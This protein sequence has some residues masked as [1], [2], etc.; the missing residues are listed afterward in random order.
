MICR[1]HCVFGLSI[2]QYNCIYARVMPGAAWIIQNQKNQLDIESQTEI[3]KMH[4]ARCV[5]IRQLKRQFV[6][7]FAFVEVLPPVN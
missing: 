7:V 1:W 4:L 3:A 5:G 2:I 6:S